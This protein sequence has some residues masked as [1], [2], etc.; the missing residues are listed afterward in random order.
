MSL[1]LV[2]TDKSGKKYGLH[3]ARDIA[4]A[5]PKY[6]DEVFHNACQQEVARIA[7]EEGKA[8]ADGLF[9]QLMDV[10]AAITDF[11]EGVL[12]DGGLKDHTSRSK[13][14]AEYVS[15]PNYERALSI[16]YKY[17]FHEVTSY[18]WWGVREVHHA[19]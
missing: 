5:Y 15:D 8:V 12:T 7:T 13:L 16:L 10:K 1:N 19:G 3:P 2:V 17:F 6:I 14:W 18:Y 11:C 9:T 4:H